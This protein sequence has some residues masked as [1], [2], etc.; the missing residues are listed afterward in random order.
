MPDPDL[1]S[2][3]PS[4]F[5]GVD[6]PEEKIAEAEALLNVLTEG[7][8][9]GIVLGMQEVVQAN[10][11]AKKVRSIAKVLLIAGKFVAPLLL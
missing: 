1:P 3:D 9:E 10:N 5:E 8:V 4:D 2:W 7:Q 11:R 6:I